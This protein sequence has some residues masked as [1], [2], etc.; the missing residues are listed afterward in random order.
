MI[1][2]TL[3]DLL[4][5]ERDRPLGWYYL[6][7]QD[8]GGCFNGGTIVRARGLGG[9][10]VIAREHGIN[11]GG[12]I[13]GV[14]LDPDYSV[15]RELHYRLATA[16]EITRVAPTLVPMPS[17]KSPEAQKGAIPGF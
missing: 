16:E 5:T 12:H 7:F 14:S 11:P 8:A 1:E 17:S 13:F 15:P 4:R 6:S 10:I 2:P 9:A 3:D